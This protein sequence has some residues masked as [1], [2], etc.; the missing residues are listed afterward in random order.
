M[1]MGKDYGH[2]LCISTPATQRPMDAK[3]VTKSLLFPPPPLP[4][5]TFPFNIP[6]ADVTR[7]FRFCHRQLNDYYDK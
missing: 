4:P 5:S 7:F 3:S 6:A 1:G 2:P